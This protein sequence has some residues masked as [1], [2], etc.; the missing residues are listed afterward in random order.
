MAPPI[1]TEKRCFPKSAAYRQLGRKAGY[2]WRIAPEADSNELPDNICWKQQ[3]IVQLVLEGDSVT[4]Y[5]LLSTDT[6]SIA[7]RIVRIGH[8]ST[9]YTNA[10]AGGA[11]GLECDKFSSETQQA[12][13]LMVWL[14]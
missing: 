8:T 12:G 4:S 7:Y 9:G 5:A 6:P 3:D 13:G 10:T 2:V 14:V 11:K 1:R